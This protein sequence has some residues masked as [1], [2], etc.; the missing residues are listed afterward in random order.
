MKYWRI[1]AMAVLLTLVGRASA[2]NLTVSDVE[3][4][5]GE[6]VNLAIEL[7]NPSKK[8]A[9]FQFDLVLPK[10]IT[11][12]KNDKG[13]LIASLDE[14][15][16]DDHTL[17]VSDMG[18]NTYRFLS[19]SMTNA[20]FYG[21][22]GTLVN[23]TLAADEDIETGKK[24]ATISSQVFTEVEGEQVK[25]SD[26]SFSINV[27]SAV[28]PEIKAD[29]KSRE[30]GED[31]PEFTY[32]VS[33]EIKGKPELT[34]TATK[35]SAVGDY[36]I[37]VGKGTVE[38][39]YTAVNGT[40]T[41]TKA[42]LVV[43]AKD[44][45][46]KQGE[47]LPT[48]E[49][50]YE[51]FKN[52]E[53]ESV[54]TK[55]PTLTTTATS[56]SAPGTYDIVISG[57]EAGNYSITHVNGKLTITQADA[58]TVTAK[59]Y[60]R[61]YGEAN[62]AFEYTSAGAALDGTPEISCEA[63][64][65]SPV[66]TYP[67]V[68][69][70]GSVKNYND[71]YVDG[72]L[73]ITKAPLTIKAGSYSK[74]QGEANPDFTLT[75]E[76]F[77]NNET[78]AV[79]TKKPTVSCEATKDSPTGDYTVTVSGAEAQNYEITYVN[80][81]LTITEAD[82]V[83]IT[84]RSY[85]RE[86]GDANPVFEYTSTGAA[87]DGSPEISCEAT[88]TSPVGTYPIVIKKGSVKNYNDTYV[89][90]TLT[91]TKAPLTIKALDCIRQRG[92]D[93]PDFEISYQGFKNNETEKVLTKKPTVSCLA[94]KESPVGDYDIV[95]TGA[96]AQNYEITHVNGKLTVI[97]AE[98]VVVTAKSYTREYGE[99]NP[100]FEFTSAGAAL[101]GTP[102][103][104]CEAT[105]T[106]PVGTYPII[107]KKG[108]VKNYNDSYVNG[109]LTITKAPLTIKPLDCVRKQGEDNPD[110]TVTYEG[111]KNNETEAVLT[112]KPTVSCKA[113]KE[114][115]A[116]D[117]DIVVSGAEAQNYDF[118]YINGTL[119]VIMADPVIV[120]AMDYTREYGEA[121]PT[122]EFTSVGAALD[123]TPEI[124]C[125]ATVNSPVGTYPI[126]IR[127][128]SVKNY[129]VSYVNGTL[130]ITKAPLTIK[131][132]DCIRKQGEDNPDFTVT[133]E[134]FKNNETESVLTKKPTAS[135]KAT[136]ESPAGKYDIVVSGAEAQNYDFVYKNGKLTITE[137]DAVVITA[138]SYTREYGEAN[139]TFEFTSVGADLDGTPEISCEATV[140]SP[141]GTYPIVIKKGSVK[142]Y[143]DTYIDGT[144]TIT[145]A[146]LTISVGDYTM[147]EGG[148]VPV[149]ELLYEGFKNNETETV[150]T[151]KPT[152]SCD[153]T[154][155]S[156]AG[157]YEIKVSGAKAQNYDI[158]YQ[159]GWL[160]IEATQGIDGIIMDGKPFNVFSIQGRKVRANA[161][162]LD[163]LLKGVYIINGKKAV[164]K[165][166]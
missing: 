103:I 146:P 40:L 41:I 60:T 31:N 25:W 109:T 28:V 145:A 102:E 129:N 45:S 44:Y 162:T 158:S 57:T 136:K 124:S 47:A 98:A 152:I 58:V 155:E 73:T 121:N 66:G 50:V 143:N 21:T 18:S 11:I 86:Y 84:A 135:C 56:G 161:T 64:A 112:K 108:S 160:T 49:A 88:A 80:G 141:V 99:A 125:E 48:F 134:G 123:G 55:K 114:S 67:I 39:D 53:T 54:L 27:P 165:L 117:Y 43:K 52:N 14:D 24:T 51:G 116:G 92:K 95:V 6:T 151:T 113:T 79:L 127:K 62:P 133:Y 149:F 90:G 81:K 144:L 137:A 77:K 34:T 130:T 139:P 118:I 36:E 70:K 5:A 35:T 156:V 74:K 75:Y 38:G 82:P 93:N 105:A 163:G 1:I 96:E 100:T 142:N 126:V 157:K 42:P 119:T 104:S 33:A 85:T 131:A 107:I 12:A 122:F 7:N 17:N 19:F 69:K 23:V 132:T 111:F 71:T 101:D 164:V 65:T 128:G 20:E 32:T 94:T 63:T 138:K 37:I 91:I 140:N 78:E 106:S 61:E 159:S 59:S 115:H 29:N 153:A 2:D 87:L 13:K 4:K 83:F 166:P 110:F 22:S 8:Y 76:G 89:N 154:S 26:V 97:D 16:I 120:S 9:A 30:Y 148:Q 68:I 150:L 46:I 72:V 10:G 15:R 3:I 147:T